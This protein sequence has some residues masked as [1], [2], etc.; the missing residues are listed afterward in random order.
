MIERFKFHCTFFVFSSNVWYAW[1][2]RVPFIWCFF[3]LELNTGH[4]FRLEIFI[5]A[6]KKNILISRSFRER[7]FQV[8]CSQPNLDGRRISNQ[9]CVC[10]CLF[11]GFQYT[12][13]QNYRPDSFHHGLSRLIYLCDVLD[14]II[15]NR[16]QILPQ[17]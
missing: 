14:E 4:C 9:S 16:N 1:M 10:I 5:K 13:V 3:V 6:S 7:K 8:H 2:L 12:Y 15:I 11:F 17:N